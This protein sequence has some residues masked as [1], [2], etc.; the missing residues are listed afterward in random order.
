[1]KKNKVIMNYLKKIMKYKM[2]KKIK[3]LQ[4]KLH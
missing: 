4:K 2:N 3:I 1:M